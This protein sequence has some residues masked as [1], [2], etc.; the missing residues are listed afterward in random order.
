MVLARVPSLRTEMKR[1][2]QL[3]ANANEM[4][5]LSLPVKEGAGCRGMVGCIGKHDW[6]G[7][8]G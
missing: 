7:V 6:G 3:D 4:R 8:P 1:P 2:P 5:L